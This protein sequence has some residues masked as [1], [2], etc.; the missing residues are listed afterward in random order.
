VVTRGVF[1]HGHGYSFWTGDD[2]NSPTLSRTAGAASALASSLAEK[3][4]SS[5]KICKVEGAEK[6]RPKRRK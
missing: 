4:R 2:F 6:R 3:V 5:C 1:T